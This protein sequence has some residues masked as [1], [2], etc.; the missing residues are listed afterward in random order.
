MSN[1]QAEE[2]NSPPVFQN[3]C[4]DN[5]EIITIVCD[6]NGLLKSNCY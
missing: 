1:T 3:D 2:A 4:N 5:Y 6:R